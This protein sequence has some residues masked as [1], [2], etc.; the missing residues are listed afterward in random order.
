MEKIVKE[1]KIFI[2]GKLACIE[3]EK[4]KKET[5]RI[6]KKLFARHKIEAKKY[7]HKLITS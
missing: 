6:L 7:Y 5:I 3:L 4:R 2:D 1:W